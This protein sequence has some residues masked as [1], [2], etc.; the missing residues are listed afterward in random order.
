MPLAVLLAPTAVLLA[1]LPMLFAPSAVARFP[2][3]VAVAPTAVA[4]FDAPVDALVPKA[5][6]FVPL[7]W[8][9]TPQPKDDADAEAPLLVKAT[10]LTTGV[11][12]VAT[13]VKKFPVW[14]GVPLTNAAL[15]EVVV[16][17][18]SAFPAVVLR[19]APVKNGA[20]VWFTAVTTFCVAGVPL[21]TRTF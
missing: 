3:A 14:T 11:V 20:V 13:P 18:V 9:F 16:T 15:V 17:P 19:V 12:T 4:L 8:A 10:A 1:P 2:V 7:A 5:I 6:A 21:T